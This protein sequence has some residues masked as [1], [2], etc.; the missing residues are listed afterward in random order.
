MLHQCLERLYPLLC[1]NHI[2][3]LLQLLVEYLDTLF[4][5]Q[6]NTQYANRLNLSCR[7]LSNRPI[8]ARLE[9]KIPHTISDC[10]E[11]LIFFY[12]LYSIIICNLPR[13]LKVLEIS[14]VAPITLLHPRMQP[15]VIDK[16][17][18]KF[19]DVIMRIKAFS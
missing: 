16:E 11:L 14:L 12:F 18:F 2:V 5:R 15:V 10:T 4:F 19:H 9:K 7:I 3:Y 1:T 17:A 8:N 13:K 6:M